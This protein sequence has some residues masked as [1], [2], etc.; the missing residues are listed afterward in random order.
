M[1]GFTCKIP[2]LDVNGCRLKGSLIIIKNLARILDGKPMSDEQVRLEKMITFGLAIEMER[3]V[4][5][6]SLFC[7]FAPSIAYWFGPLIGKG[8]NP[9]KIFDYSQELKDFLQEKRFFSG[10]ENPGIN[11]LSLYGIIEPFQ[12]AGNA[13]VNQLL[14]D[15][16]DPLRIWH[17][18]MK[19]RV[20][21]LWDKV[22]SA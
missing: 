18:T 16:E 6:N 12:E 3:S 8:K 14:G 10:H 7:C 9:K 2:V 22:E 15:I 4:S 13:V 11:D 21:S 20:P 17:N 5:M 19:S 1:P